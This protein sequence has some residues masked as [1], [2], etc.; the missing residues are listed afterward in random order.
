MV[1]GWLGEQFDFVNLGDGGDVHGRQ[2]CARGSSQGCDFRSRRA[3]VLTFGKCCMC[4]VWCA[5]GGLH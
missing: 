4:G 3:G 1:R 2:Q 5:L